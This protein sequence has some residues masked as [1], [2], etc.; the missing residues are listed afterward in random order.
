MPRQLSILHTA[1]RGSRAARR[2]VC[3]PRLRATLFASLLSLAVT[4]AAA[5]D[6]LFTPARDARALER[7]VGPLSD[8]Q[9]DRFVLGRSFFAATWVEAPASTTARDGLGPLFNASSCTACHRRNG[10]GSRVD[11]VRPMDD[12][13]VLRLDGD[14]RY[15]DQIATR[16]IPGVPREAAVSVLPAWVEFTYADGERRQLFAP[17]FVLEDWRYGLPSEPA[18][19]YPR[20]APALTGLGL[21]ERISETSILAHA[22]PD[23]LDGDGISGKPN[24]VWSREHRDWRLGRFGWKAGVAGL[25]DQVSRALIEDLGLTSKWFP[26]ENCSPVQSQCA[27]AYSSSEPDIDAGRGDR[28]LPEKS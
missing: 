6:S 26:R 9:L 16:A 28:L 23:D 21:V 17:K 5:S 2:F 3:A 18:D 7:A 8:E 11:G 1:V 15:G 14:A 19:A 12:S 22:D 13:I 10:G 27:Q 25:L 4:A 20:R 24:I